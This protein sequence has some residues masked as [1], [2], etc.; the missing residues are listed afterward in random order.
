MIKFKTFF[1]NSGGVTADEKVNSWLVKHSSIRICSMQYQQSRFGDHSICIMYEAAPDDLQKQC[2][3]LR[4]ENQRLMR[5]KMVDEAVARFI[6]GSR[7]T[8]KEETNV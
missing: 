3:E 8:E 6:Y 4:E 7:A 1:G 2:E 5:Q